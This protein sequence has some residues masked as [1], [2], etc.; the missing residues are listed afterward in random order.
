M[1]LGCQA[2]SGVGTPRSASSRGS[3]SSSGWSCSPS[4]SR[5]AADD[6]QA[7]AV[8]AAQRRDRLGQLDRLADRRLEVELVVVGQAQR[9]RARRRPAAAGRSSGRAT[10][11]T[12]PARSDLDRD[13]RCRAGSGCTRARAPSCRSGVGEDA[14]GWSRAAGPGRRSA[15]PAR[16]PRRGRSS[17]PST[18]VGRGRRPASSAEQAGD[19][20]GERPV[21]SDGRSTSPRAAGRL[22]RLVLPSLAR[23]RRRRRRPVRLGSSDRRGARRA[24]RCPS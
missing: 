4:S 12:P 20:P 22:G 17:T 24:G 1:R 18:V 15:R 3:M 19:V 8:R 21:R 9:R 10:A 7:R 16:G 6:A 11:G 13:S 5:H 2:S 14:R 23:R